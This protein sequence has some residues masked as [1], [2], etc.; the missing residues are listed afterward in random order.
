MIQLRNE[1]NWFR[2]LFR[3][4]EKNTEDHSTRKA[5]VDSNQ[6]CQLQSST[7]LAGFD[8]LL[9]LLSYLHATSY[10]FESQDR[11]NIVFVYLT[12]FVFCFSDNLLFLVS[13]FSVS[14][15]LTF[16]SGRIYP[17]CK[18]E[19][20]QPLPNQNHS[21]PSLSSPPQFLKDHAETAA[22]PMLEICFHCR[23][24]PSAGVA[25]A[26]MRLQWVMPSYV[27]FGVLLLFLLF[28]SQINTIDVSY[29]CYH[30]YYYYQISNATEDYLLLKSLM[31]LICSKLDIFYR[32]ASFVLE[33]HYVYLLTNRECWKF[34]ANSFRR[35][36]GLDLTC[37]IALNYFKC[38]VSSA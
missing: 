19:V 10:A 30:N 15:L 35:P 17:E 33:S 22:V 34:V 8:I 2:V 21:W 36:I 14:P 37:L 31:S 18:T 16:T 26:L 23:R 3:K 4:D 24:K 29:C 38:H 32:H 13:S 12:E 9:K 1:S 7:G 20:L 11:S 28:R 25:W 6:V 5:E 27:C